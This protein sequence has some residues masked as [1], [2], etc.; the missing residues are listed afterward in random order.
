MSER[1]SDGVVV[2]YDGSAQSGRAVRWAAEEARLRGV[3]LTVCHAWGTYASAG[4]MAIPITDLRV[5]AERVLAEG[6]EHAR[7]DTGDVRAL[8]GN[9]ASAPI[10]LEAA[11]NA[12]LLVVGSHGHG[13]FAGLLL[14]STAAGLA[15]HTPCPLVVVRSGARRDGA[16]GPVVAGVDGSASSL[17]ALALAFTEADL[18]RTELVVR[19]AWPGSADAEGLPLVDAE[20]LRELAEE[21]LARFVAPLREQNPKIAV[22]TEVV[23]GSAREVLLHAAEEAALLVVGSRGAG[24][25]RGLLLGSVGQAL[26]HHAA[27]PVAIAPHR[28]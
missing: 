11:A 6:V 20:G 1:R 24:G 5:A 25:F 15:A 27:C 13:G 4:P 16:A 8:L 3:P 12:E 22:R 2:G 21:R 7:Q 28:D 23:R 9:G 10:L 19:L 18:R 14:G 17:E 26:L